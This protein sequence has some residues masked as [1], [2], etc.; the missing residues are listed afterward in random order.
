MESWNQADGAQDGL[1]AAKKI[2]VLREIIRKRNETRANNPEWATPIPIHTALMVEAFSYGIMSA[3]FWFKGYRVPPNMDLVINWIAFNVQR[4]YPENFAQLS[5]N[6]YMAK[7]HEWMEEAPWVR[8]WNDNPKVNNSEE[9]L[10]LI[11]RDA[12]STRKMVAR[13]F[14]CLDSVAINAAYMVE[15]E[16]QLRLEFSEY[17]NSQPF[18]ISE[19]QPSTTNKPK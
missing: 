4:E 15:K 10:Y 14:V 16:W 17:I 5:L 3:D 19:P 1:E 8:E 6:D 13:P 7:L 2:G 12:E 9:R 11:L 18:Q